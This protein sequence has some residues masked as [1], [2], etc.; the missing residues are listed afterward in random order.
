M[1]DN[2]SFDGV[3]DFEG[4]AE[5]QEQ[6]VT[7]PADQVESETSEEVDENTEGVKE[8]EVTDPA[9]G[10]Q[11]AEDNARF[12]AAR[13]KAEKER[14]E[15]IAKMQKEHEQA[16]DRMVADF[17]LRNP[18]N[19]QPITTRAEM[20]AYKRQHAEEERR[21]MLEKAED[22]GLTEEDVKAMV[23]SDPEY[24]EAMRLKQEAAAAREKAN[25][26]TYKVF[27]ENAMKEVN[28]LDPSVKSMDDLRAH[29]SFRA[30]DEYVKRGYS[31]PDAFEKANKT[32]IQ[33]RQRAA[34]EQ[35]IRNSINGRGHLDSNS[36]RGDGGVSVP[37]DVLNEIRALNPNAS[38][39]EIEK[40]YAKDIR[41]TKKG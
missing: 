19:G 35:Q 37:A 9:E 20:E 38:V 39:A 15:A 22:G 1:S 32:A 21:Q 3:F 34:L 4:G 11:S 40:W 33:E 5:A 24:Q 23:H 31:I 13:R 41:R 14:D 6:E 27:L 16:M 18:Y 10:K 2:I 26:E 28:K 29:E 8:Q 12:A 17:G 7:E 25:E 30:V 36:P